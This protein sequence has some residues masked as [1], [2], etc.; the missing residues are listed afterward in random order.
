M[1]FCT[2]K[3]ILFDVNFLD[4][5]IALPLGYLIFKGYRRGLIFEL[6]SLAGLIVGSIVAV[7]FAHWFASSVGLKGDNA[8]LIAFFLLFIAVVFLSMLVGKLVERS[9]KLVHMGFANNI[10]GAISGL[11][12]GVCI[13]GVLLY[14]IT[15]ID[16]KERI[17]TKETKQASMLYSPVQRAGKH[18]V[19]HMELYIKNR[20]AH[21][22]DEP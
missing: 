17:L 3:K 14:F 7:R 11:A 2:P 20:K 4:L 6:A 5:I 18:L 13:I 21:M 15:F 10:A 8:Y 19:G 16:L 22:D 9:V 1:Y 12:K